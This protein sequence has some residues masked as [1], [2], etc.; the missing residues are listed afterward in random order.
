MFGDG[1]ANGSTGSQMSFLSASGSAVSPTPDVHV[2]TLSGT[3]LSESV[4]A[5]TGGAAP[6]WTFSGDP[7]LDAQLLTNVSAPGGVMFNYF[8]FQ[9]G[10]LSTVPLATPLSATRRGGPPTSRSH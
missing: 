10:Q 9:N 3:T 2:I 1:T 8:D 4:Y 5:A 6:S 7:Q